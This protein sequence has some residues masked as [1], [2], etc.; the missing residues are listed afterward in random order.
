MAHPRVYLR[1]CGGTDGVTS[2]MARHV[3]LSPRVRRHP[4]DGA[5][6]HRAHGSISACAE[7]PGYDTPL[8]SARGVY[9]RVCGGT[10]ASCLSR[11][12]VKGLSPRVRRHLLKTLPRRRAVRSI[13]A[14]A[15]AP[16]NTTPTTRTG[17]VYLRVC[18]GTSSCDLGSQGAR[19]LSPRVRRHRCSVLRCRKERR[20]ISACAEAPQATQ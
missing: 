15:E 2:D 9:L 8:L 1:V 18:G 3:G 7:A 20:S 10:R 6:V 16:G 14:C 11:T 17:W 5:Y 4:T 12:K 19:G 13:S